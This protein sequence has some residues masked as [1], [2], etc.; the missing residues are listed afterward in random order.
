MTH[1]KQIAE[2]A[3]LTYTCP[4]N[5]DDLAEVPD[6]PPN[7]DP[8]LDGK[9]EL[10][11]LVCEAAVRLLPILQVLHGVAPFIKNEDKR[12]EF[13]SSIP[14]NFSNL[15]STAARVHTLIGSL[16]EP[17]LAAVAVE[18][19]DL[20]RQTLLDIEAALQ[21]VDVLNAALV[22]SQDISGLQAS[23]VFKNEKEVSL[24]Q[25]RT[26]STED[27]SL[28]K[29]ATDFGS[30][31][32]KFH[33]VI[34]SYIGAVES[35]VAAKAKDEAMR[36]Q[37]PIFVMPDGKVV[38]GE[39]HLGWF[40]CGSLVLDEVVTSTKWKESLR[41][42]A[43]QLTGFDAR[44]LM[45]LA[46]PESDTNT[47]IPK[48]T[49][50]SS[51]PS[52]IGSQVFHFP[53]HFSSPKWWSSPCKPKMIAAMSSSLYI[54]GDDGNVYEW[55]AGTDSPSC[56]PKT[57]GGEITQ[58]VHIASSRLRATVV[59]EN[60]MC[61][62]WMDQSAP[63]ELSLLNHDLQHMKL[64]S[65]PGDPIQVEPNPAAS[66]LASSWPCSAC[67]FINENMNAATCD[68]CASPRQPATA[69]QSAG[70]IEVSIQS[71]TVQ[72]VHA[73]QTFKDDP[74]VHLSVS[75]FATA[76]V[77]ESGSCYWWGIAPMSVA[78]KIPSKVSTG[79][80][81][82][83]DV[84]VVDKSPTTRVLRS[85]AS[86]AVQFGVLSHYPPIESKPSDI[87]VYVETEQDFSGVKDVQ[88]TIIC[89]L[90]ERSNRT[91]DNT[92]EHRSWSHEKL[93]QTFVRLLSRPFFHFPQ[94]SRSQSA[95][96]ATRG[97]SDDTFD[98]KDARHLSG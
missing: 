4:Q 26:P 84:V 18:K 21:T 56:V 11:I 38:R 19:I 49:Q 77:C 88:D 23:R 76:V 40:L 97:G 48:A 69:T 78:S 67:T 70:T 31:I 39:R 95:I 89:D 46:A 51:D 94:M 93:F 65:L 52:R 10:S 47:V 16:S 90:D 59:A 33:S 71:A 58:I 12:A 8:A 37:P 75:S 41:G 30:S 15:S 22:Y 2:Q 53:T 73:D 1:C 42:V 63:S 61:A 66:P 34:N 96:V 55:C 7:K 50:D 81:S 54:L 86:K 92:T 43:P 82:I 27:P 64:A 36:A 62:S 74:I 6:K 29:A 72:S 13:G 32:L 91:K 98:R 83:G 35:L 14:L 68:V 80:I 24:W 28:I 17:N 85:T 57:F 9:V 60:G 5:V 25:K 3:A 20:V 45:S 44:C 79:S 87:A